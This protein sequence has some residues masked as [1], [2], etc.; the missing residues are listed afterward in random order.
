MKGN[1]NNSWFKELFASIK[2]FDKYQ[3]Y[4][5]EKTSKS[6]IYF[7]K[8]IAV[9]TLIL[10]LILTYK[11]HLEKEDLVKYINENISEIK[12]ENNNLA[13]NDNKELIL[14]N[15]LLSNSMIIINTSN[16][17]EEKLKSYKENIS[18][19][20]N[21][22]ILLKN[23]I[24]INS[25]INGKDDEYYYE[26][27]AKNYNITNLNK[28]EILKKLNEN[29]MIIFYIMFFIFFY[30]C[31]F[32]MYFITSMMYAI[33]LALLGR[34]TSI[35]LR[36]PLKYKSVL[37]MAL[38]ALTLPTIL[39]LIYIIVNWYTGFN[40]EYFQV[41]YSAISYVYIITGILMIKADFIK[42]Q[43]ELNKILEEQ[44]KIR[45]EY[46]ANGENTE[47]KENDGKDSNNN[48]HKDNNDEEKRS[49]QSQKPEIDND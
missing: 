38:H 39:S 28:E 6:I 10:G 1:K 48:G 30:I 11:I 20:D 27:I 3:D 19:Y 8:V 22:I 9:F 21:G 35:L 46:K 40:I 7:L 5:T 32:I 44:Q 13:V 12:F 17:E 43:L 36:I 23:K 14:E 15:K 34:I 47:S 16:I 29:Q 37:N 41:M 2:D 26:E 45:E 42:K 31:M 24:I 25:N 33:M 49:K 4:A 18:D